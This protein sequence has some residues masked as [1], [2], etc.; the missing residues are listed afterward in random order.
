MCKMTGLPDGEMLT[1]FN[2][3]GVMYRLK[4]KFKGQ[5]LAKSI[6]N[7]NK[8]FTYLLEKY[9]IPLYTDHRNEEITPNIFR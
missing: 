6:I 1:D 7:F 9:D 8:Y 5:L 4:Y 3:Y 2:L